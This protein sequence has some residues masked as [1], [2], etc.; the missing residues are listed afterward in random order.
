MIDEY[1][2]YGAYTLAFLLVIFI[3]ELLYRKFGAEPEHTRKFSHISSAVLCLS[4]PMFFRNHWFV[5][6]LACQSFGLLFISRNW[7]I[8]KSIDQVDR[9]TYGSVVFPLS[10]YLSFFCF[11]YT[12]DPAF[13]YIPM[14]ILAFSDPLAAVSGQKAGW[15]HEKFNFSIRYMKYGKEN[16]T[17]IGSL[18]FFISAF[19][20]SLIL[21]SWFYRLNPLELAVSAFLISVF[22]TFAEA[23]TG[24]GLDNLSVPVTVIFTLL[25]LKQ[26]Y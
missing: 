8:F 26:N 21:L 23:W 5:F 10:I 19:L 2:S 9:D 16:K 17:Y 18:S 14:I 20:C 12:G 24:K 11:D 15:L 3:S 4:F 13:F 25:V 6:A 7:K 22:S 1:I